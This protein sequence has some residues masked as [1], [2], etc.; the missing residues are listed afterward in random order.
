MQHGSSSNP[1]ARSK[2][3]NRLLLHEFQIDI[4]RAIGEPS[5]ADSHQG[6]G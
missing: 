4:P 5:C 1:A 3:M 2:T 6:T